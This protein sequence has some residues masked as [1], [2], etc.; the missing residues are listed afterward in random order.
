MLVQYPQTFTLPPPYGSGYLQGGRRD[1]SGLKKRIARSAQDSSRS[2]QDN[3]VQC[4]TSYATFPA[5][6]KY[7]TA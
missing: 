7:R 2:A 6:V 3:S 4:E 5:S 1:N